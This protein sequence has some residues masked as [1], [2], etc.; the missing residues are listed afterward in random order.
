MKPTSHKKDSIARECQ[1]LIGR[2]KAMYISKNPNKKINYLIDIYT[3]WFRS[4]L[5]FC[6]TYK[7]ESPNSIANEFEDKFARLEIT[8]YDKYNRSRV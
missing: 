4:Y 3:K 7:S 6:G 2:L 8:K 1:P 5:Y